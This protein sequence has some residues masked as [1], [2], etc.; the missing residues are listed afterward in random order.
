[1]KNPFVHSTGISTLNH[2][3]SQCHRNC[4]GLWLSLLTQLIH[5][6]GVPG[7]WHFVDVLGL[8]DELLAMLP[9]PVVALIV[10]FPKGDKVRCPVMTSVEAQAGCSKFMCQILTLILV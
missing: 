10:L 2:T 3:I 5:T 7:K 1:M 8:D 9:Q 4:D 6:L